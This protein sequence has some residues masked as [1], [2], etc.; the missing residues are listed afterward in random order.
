MASH[1]WGS[2]KRQH[3]STRFVWITNESY[4]VAMRIYLAPGAPAGKEKYKI[5]FIFN[6]EPTHPFTLLISVL[7]IYTQLH[8]SMKPQTPLGECCGGKMPRSMTEPTAHG[9]ARRTEALGIIFTGP[10][11][12]RENMHRKDCMIRCK[13]ER[14][15]RKGANLFREKI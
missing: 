3:V 15:F 7:T 2:Q 8:F 6:G 12:S 10:R 4:R 13:C 5:S 1:S 14:V 11:I 9:I